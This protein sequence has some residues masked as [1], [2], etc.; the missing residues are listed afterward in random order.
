MSKIKH[1]PIKLTQKE[2]WKAHDNAYIEG[3]GEGLDWRDFLKEINKIL[4]RKQKRN[5]P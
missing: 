2:L 5:R 3:W 1:R 4:L